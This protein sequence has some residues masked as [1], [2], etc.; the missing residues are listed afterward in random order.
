M[1]TNNTISRISKSQIEVWEM[2]E[3][4][5][6]LVKALPLNEAFHKLMEHSR[7]TTE[8]YLKERELKAN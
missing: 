2:K 1:E 5:Y 8:K 3:N 4:L 7:I 6:N